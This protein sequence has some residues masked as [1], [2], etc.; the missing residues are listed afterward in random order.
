MEDAA[1]GNHDHAAAAWVEGRMDAAQQQEFAAHLAACAECQ[2]QVAAMR[3]ALT[4]RQPV[5]VMPVPAEPDAKTSGGGARRAA[6]IL[7][8]ALL[9]L[10]V[11]FALGWSVWQMMNR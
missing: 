5:L 7:A 6:L 2:A 3:A 10:I 4:Q 8:A 1:P 9:T 11:G